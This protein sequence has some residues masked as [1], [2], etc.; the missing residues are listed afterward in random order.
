MKSAPWLTPTPEMTQTAG[1]AEGAHRL[2]QRCAGW[3]EDHCQGPGGRPLRRAG[4]PEA[5]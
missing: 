1:A 2:D 4:S 3:G 5:L